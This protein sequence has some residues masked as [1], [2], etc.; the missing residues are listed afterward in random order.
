MPETPQ[1]TCPNG[2]LETPTRIRVIERLRNGLSYRKVAASLNISATTVHRIAHNPTSRRLGKN[3]PGRQKILS[4]SDIRYL[5]QTTT[6]NWD[7]RSFS[8]EN[9]AKDCGL[10]CS[11]TTVRRAMNQ[12]GYHRCR[13]CK[14]PFISKAN[15][16]KR[17]SYA[18][19]H[20]DLSTD[21]W[22][23]HIY[24]DVAA[25]NTSAEGIKWA[26]CKVKERYH[27]D[28]IQSSF[29]SG[30]SSFMIW[31]AIGWNYKSPLIFVEGS[32]KRG[33]MV[34]KDYEEQILKPIISPLFLGDP[35]SRWTMLSSESQLIEDAAGPHGIKGLRAKKEEMNIP[36]HPRPAS[37][38]DLN[39]I[40]HCWRY[41][42]QRIRAYPQYP[43]TLTDLRV[44]VQQE[45]ENMPL[46]YVNSLILSIPARLRSCKARKGAAT[47]F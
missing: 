3:R 40:E 47:K 13:R 32:G 23:Q 6:K 1:K 2:E 41:I 30:R 37:S 22:K 24:S 16:E 36:I 11:W 28:C 34:Q 9:L 10:Q 43:S 45:W 15:I 44:A 27:K 31:A 29:W 38:P 19:E 39:P 14:R 21:H 25:F 26:T 42:K 4:D 20:S 12:A 17:Y 8:W 7:S 5:I 46:E 33:G 35:A 18:I